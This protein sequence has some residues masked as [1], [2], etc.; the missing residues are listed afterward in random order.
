MRTIACFDCTG[1]ENAA[2]LVYHLAWMYAD[3]GL[4]V[5]AADL[6]P[7]ARLS[8]MFLDDDRLEAFWEGGERLLSVH[9]AFQPLLGGQADLLPAHRE[10]VSPG[11]V[12]LVGDPGL[13]S[14]ED[15]FAREWT[16]C[17][18][19]EPSTFQGIGGLRRILSSAAEGVEADVVLIDPGPTPSALQRAAL[20]AAQDV[21]L[22]VAP[23][24][25]SIQGLK[26]LGH[27]LGRW[28]REWALRSKAA[29]EGPVA[30]PAGTMTP[31]GYVLLRPPVRLDRPCGAG[32]RWS[33][34]VAREF[35]R[36]VL[37]E[38]DPGERLA[39]AAPFCL[40][41]LQP[42]DSL[43]SLAR[44]ARR[45]MFHLKPADGAVGGHMQ[46]VL[47]CHRDFLELARRIAGRCRVVLP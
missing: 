15:E 35:R 19:G 47:E 13:S 32:G 33:E 17:M 43:L 39:A 22:T 37:G 41:V 45:P 46:A 4:S 36:S 31:V 30:P 3:L 25:F 28:R 40:Q 10:A 38:A 16:R 18:E 20:V 34:R 5:V 44:E 2:F 42:S 12:L 1:D 29:P 8:R 23:D 27:G 26:H 6:G 7:R 14:A 11:L 21:V 24:L 9:G